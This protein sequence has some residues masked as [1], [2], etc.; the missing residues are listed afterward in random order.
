MHIDGASNTQGSGAGLI[1]ASLEGDVTEHALRFNFKISNNGAEYEVLI[2]GLEII[3]EL[4]TKRLKVFIDS[5]LIVGQVQD[6]YEA[7]DSI[8]SQYLHHTMKL[9]K[10]FSNLEIIQIPRL[11]NAQADALS[12]LATSKYSDLNQKAFIKILERLSI[13]VQMIAQLDHEPS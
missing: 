5:Q 1:L 7:K 8:I 10:S 12:H 9:S 13:E 11:E 6:H 3:K 4:N 2:G